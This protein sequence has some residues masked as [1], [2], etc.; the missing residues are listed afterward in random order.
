MH[1]LFHSTRI[2]DPV[3]TS[4]AALIELKRV[5]AKQEL[6]QWFVFKRKFFAKRKPLTCHYCGRSKLRTKGSH[7]ENGNALGTLATVDHIIPTSK[8]GAELDEANCVVACCRCNKR[9]GDGE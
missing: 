2:E 5:Y 7:H 3:I 9:K 8:G 1:K 4:L 6:K